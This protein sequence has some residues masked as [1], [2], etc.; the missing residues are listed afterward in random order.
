MKSPLALLVIILVGAVAVAVVVHN[1]TRETTSSEFKYSKSAQEIDD[2]YYKPLASIIADAYYH[3]NAFSNTPEDAGKD[4][5]A[6]S[7]LDGLI[8]SAEITKGTQ[9]DNPD[10]D[11]DGIIDSVDPAPLDPAEGKATE[12]WPG[13]GP[14]TVIPVY[15]LVIDTFYKNIIN[16]TL[17]ETQ[18]GHSTQAS[19]GDH[20]RFLVYASLTSNNPTDTLPCTITDQLG[21]SLKYVLDSTGTVNYYYINGSRNP[22][23]DEWLKNGLKL[24]IYPPT[25][26]NPT[27][28]IEIYFEAIVWKDP[29]NVLNVTLNSAK[30]EAEVRTQTDFAFIT[31]KPTK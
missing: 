9:C 1:Y 2:T 18:W 7:D 5:N 21:K 14:I 24:G 11:G 17:G 3:Q 23:P 28:I 26:G 25:P 4:P 10:T 27:T 8:N 31:I 16:Q 6:D 13:L 15:R 30:I 12:I 29:A 22:L 19:I 20:V